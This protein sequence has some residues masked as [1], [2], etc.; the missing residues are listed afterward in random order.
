MV[1]RVDQ[2]LQ[3]ELNLPEGLADPSV[4]VLD[5]CC[6]TGTYLVEVLHNIAARLKA[7][8]ED[9]LAAPT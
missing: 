5:A 2:V 7:R 8:G 3:T 9:A 6:G 4:V 1:A